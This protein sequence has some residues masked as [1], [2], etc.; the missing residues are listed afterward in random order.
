MRRRALAREPAAARAAGNGLLAAAIAVALAAA[1]P[2]A[3]GAGRCGTHPWCDTSLS[4][5]KRAAAAA[6]RAHARRE[7]RRCSAA[8]S[9]SGVAGGEGTHTGTLDGVPRA[10]PADDLPPD[11]PLGS[12]SGQGDGDARVDGAGGDVRPRRSPRTTAARGRQRGQ[13]KGNDV[14]YAPTVNIMRTPLCGRTFE[15]YGE[16]PFLTGHTRRRAGSRALQAQG[17]IANVKHFAANNQEGARHRSHGQ[18]RGQPLQVN[19]LVDERTLREIYLPPSRP[20]SRRP[21]SAR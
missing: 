9:S 3:F 8:T 21:T 17:V 12:R 1:A 20:R 11:G 7:D 18:R 14:V 5:D 10:R 6:S 15:A 13:L 16:D 19:A 2:A 4:P